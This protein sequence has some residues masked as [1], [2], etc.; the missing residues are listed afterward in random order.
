MLSRHVRPLLQLAALGVVL[1]VTGS[2]T[3][4]QQPAKGPVLPPINPAVARLDQTI[5]GLDG[6]GFAIAYSEAAGTI[7]AACEDDTIQMWSKDVLLNVRSGNSTANVLRG[8]RG[9]VTDLAWNGGPII[10]S[11]GVD[12]K[13]LLWSATDGKVLQTIATPQLVRALA[14]SPDGRVV[15][16]GGDDPAIQLWETDTGK[17]AAKLTGH[18]DWV[19][20]LT[21]SPDGKYLASGGYDGAVILWDVAGSKKLRELKADVKLAPGT[22]PEPV[23]IW[24]VAFSPDSKTVAVGNSEGKIDLFG[25]EDGKL[26]RSLPGHGSAVTSLQFHPS[27]TVLAS[28]SRDRTVR[29]WNPANAQALKVLEGHTAWVQGLAFVTEGTRLASVGADRTVR[30]WD[31]TAGK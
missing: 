20:C 24:S 25:A 3:L 8:H 22:I 14:M 1:A 15:A 13:L 29:L 23:V 18:A 2:G 26:L 4:A 9:T 12:R 31:L 28:A 11:A 10:A 7:A 6:P 17:P 27:N 19:L 16:S 5:E 21:F 30:V